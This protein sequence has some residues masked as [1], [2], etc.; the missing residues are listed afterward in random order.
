MMTVGLPAPR[1]TMMM[2]QQGQ[3]RGSLDQVHHAQ[4]NFAGGGIKVGEN[5]QRDADHDGTQQ[6]G[7]ND[8]DV[9]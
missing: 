5:S 6:G 9:V 8:R 3:C 7:D 4:D 1:K 2:P